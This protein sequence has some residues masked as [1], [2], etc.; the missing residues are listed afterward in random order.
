MHM[1]VNVG[2]RNK[3][4]APILENPAR[5]LSILLPLKP[6]PGASCNYP[7]TMVHKRAKQLGDP[8][9]DHFKSVFVRNKAK[10][11]LTHPTKRNVY[12]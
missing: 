10:D 4:R 12:S 9:F 7:L 2:G 1:M 6:T 11:G 8:Q 5:N 3:I